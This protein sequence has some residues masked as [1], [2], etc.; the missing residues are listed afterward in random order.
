MKI[1][2]CV[3][4]L[5]ALT[6]SSTA[7][8][9]DKAGNDDGAI[10][11]LR[12]LRESYKDIQRFEATLETTMDVELAGDNEALANRFR[13]ASETA[14]L[15][16]KQPKHY[17]YQSPQI[18]FIR[19][20]DT[21]QVG[22]PRRLQYVKGSKPPPS[23]RVW[24]TIMSS[25]GGSMP[26]DPMALLSSKDSAWDE[27]LST[28]QQVSMT[29]VS[30]DNGERVQISGVMPSMMMPHMMGEGD[31]PVLIRIDP[32]RMLVT[33]YELDMTSLMNDMS[34]FQSEHRGSKSA[35]RARYEKMILTKSIT[36]QHVGL[37]LDADAFTVNWGQLG[38]QQA[39][40]EMHDELLTDQTS[41]LLGKHAPPTTSET[42]DG[43]EFALENLRGN[44]VV[45][46]FWSTWSGSGVR[47]M[48]KLQ[49]VNEHFNDQPV[50]M[51][52]VNQ[53]P[54]GNESVQDI[55]DRF[56]ITLPQI[57]DPEGAIRDTYGVFINYGIVMIDKDGIVQAV[58]KRPMSGLKEKLQE[59]IATLLDGGSLLAGDAVAAAETLRRK[60]ADAE[61]GADAGDDTDELKETDLVE[62]ESQRLEA[63]EPIRGAQWNINAINA[64][65]NGD[66]RDELVISSRGNTFEIIY[67][68]GSRESLTL[69]GLPSQYP[70]Q[71]HVIE[72]D[73]ET[74]LAAGTHLTGPG[75]ATRCY[76]GVWQLDGQK[77]WSKRLKLPDNAGVAPYHDAIDLNGDGRKELVIA[78][79]VWEY[80]ESYSNRQNRR[81]FFIAYNADGTLLSR[82]ALR[83][84]TVNGIECIH[85]ESGQ[86]IIHL[87]T[88]SSVLRYRYQLDGQ[89]ATE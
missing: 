56:E 67:G 87:I 27:F 70:T 40:P 48:L 59:D 10:D 2:N 17:F 81:A 83:E 18:V 9:Q 29:R 31:M 12:Q 43:T 64:D 26:F 61:P 5:A 34:S 54:K 62:F 51:I 86:P 22:Y 32:D 35:P 79:N 23:A 39:D 24:E 57:I 65:L 49:E 53:N 21:I 68:D 42:L 4:V 60:T 11:L 82:T 7:V 63:L 25:T 13:N 77:V 72:V 74:R 89:P 46:S 85:D 41:P 1:V 20:D 37:E 47:T 33:E 44:V 36:E 78:M 45:L 75:V 30:T 16:F 71:I 15:R 52:G 38:Y 69:D 88:T 84:E 8:G 58:Y 19:T 6:L 14:T 28:L 66:G 3:V 73:G 76:I 80:D 50:R 55:L